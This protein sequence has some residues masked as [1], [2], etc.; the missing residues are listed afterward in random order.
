LQTADR[1][2]LYS[3]VCRLMPAVFPLLSTGECPPFSRFGFDSKD[4]MK[5]SSVGFMM[6]SPELMHSFY[7]FW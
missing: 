4:A 3:A 5:T 7:P 1:S 2:N 6:I